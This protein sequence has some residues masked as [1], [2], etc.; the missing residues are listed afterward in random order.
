MGGAGKPAM[1]I[2]HPVDPLSLRFRDGTNEHLI[3][4]R[5]PPPGERGGGGLTQRGQK[6]NLILNKVDQLNSERKT[7]LIPMAEQL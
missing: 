6:F 5:S 7:L 3:M 2:R 4:Q 1:A